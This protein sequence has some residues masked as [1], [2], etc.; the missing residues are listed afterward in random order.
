MKI[1]DASIADENLW[2]ISKDLIKPNEFDLKEI[3][4]KCIFRKH[5]DTDIGTI[6]TAYRKY[7]DTLSSKSNKCYLLNQYDL[8]RA[9]NEEA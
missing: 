1:I 4:L 3:C 6:R 9:H 5:S 2:K 7:P 8:S